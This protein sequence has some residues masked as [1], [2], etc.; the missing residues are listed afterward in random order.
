[1]EKSEE[2]KALEERIARARAARAQADAEAEQR[3]ELAELE[4]QA[5]L[6]EQAVSD[7]PHIAAARAQ[8]GEHGVSVVD[9]DL[10]AL[11]VKAP[12]HLKWNALI[13]KGDK[14]THVDIVGV[15]RSCLVYPDWPRADKMLEAAPG[16]LPVLIE[17]ITALASSRA[18]VR[19][20]K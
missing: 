1:M 10:G 6:E 19:A 4:R 14:M 13:A 3:A 9:S 18:K 20:G 5:Q 8:H 7:A 15:V 12:N 17:A 2:I 11:V 16:L